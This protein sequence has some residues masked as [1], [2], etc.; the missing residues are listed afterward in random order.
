MPNTAGP[1]YLNFLYQLM[2]FRKS[3][4]SSH[5]RPGAVHMFNKYPSVKTYIIE[6][7]QERTWVRYKRKKKDVLGI[8][9]AFW[10]ICVPE[11]NY[12][13]ATGNADSSSCAGCAGFLVHKSQ[14]LALAAA[15]LRLSLFPDCR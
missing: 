8:F 1:H 6:I 14:L 13:T 3:S 10:C 4:G 11:R 15:S 12:H 7:K 9:L 2:V 5:L